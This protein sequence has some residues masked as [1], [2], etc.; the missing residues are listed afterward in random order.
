MVTETDR[1]GVN[2]LL[3][4]IVLV[5]LI[6]GA[7][8]A[9]PPVAAVI[10]GSQ[11]VMIAASAWLTWRRMGMVWMAVAAAVAAMALGG[12]AALSA[13]GL[14]MG[15]IALGWPFASFWS[16]VSVPVLVL[17][18]HWFEAK[19]WQDWR[20]HAAHVRFRH[21]FLFRH[22]PDLRSRRA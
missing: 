11:S 1:N 7:A 9:S 21:M 4:G 16:A 22:I 18:S 2:G 6:Q 8:T 19:Q 14:T 10:W 20:A 5:A 3:T 17:A 13:A 15:Q 12:I